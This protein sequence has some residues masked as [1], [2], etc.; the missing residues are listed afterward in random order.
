[1]GELM[2]V[3]DNPVARARMHVIRARLAS[4]D[5]DD[6]TALGLLHSGLTLIGEQ[7]DQQ[8]LVYAHR[9]AAYSSL[10]RSNWTEAAEHL[11]EMLRV[12]RAT[13]D[14]ASLARALDAVGETLAGV[15]Q[16][17]RAVGMAESASA[18]RAALGVKLAPIEAIRRDRWLERASLAL[19]VDAQAAR[20]AGKMAGLADAVDDALAACRALSGQLKEQTF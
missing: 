3:R 15:G 16:F 4:L 9:L 12:G 20:A 19:G 7:G 17:E 1:L 13:H 6:A 14:R 10:D 2:A 11:S 5:G 8:G 18:L